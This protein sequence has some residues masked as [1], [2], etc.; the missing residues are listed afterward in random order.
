MKKIFLLFLITC[1]FIGEAFAQ[2]PPSTQGSEF[3]FS[4]MRARNDREK[5][6][7]LLVSSPED[8]TIKLTNPQTL[9]TN[10]YNVIAG[11]VL[12]IKLLYIPK[13]GSQENNAPASFSPSDISNYPHIDCYT[14]K[15]NTIQ[16]MGYLV[17]AY[18]PGDP[19]TEVK[20]SIY[21]SMLG[22]QTS[23]AANVL[24]ID[25]LGNEYYVVTRDGNN[26][27]SYDWPAEA[28]IMATEDNT[29][30]EISPTCLIE[31]QA[32]LDLTPTFDII[33]NK[34]QTYLLRSYSSDTNDE[35]R[36]DLTG[37]IIKVKDD[38]GT[39]KCKKI[40]V[41]AGTQH[42][43]GEN[44][45]H[46]NG[47]YEYEQLFPVHLWGNSFMVVSTLTGLGAPESPDVV[48]IVASKP[49]TKVIVNGI[50]VATLNQSEYHELKLSTP[51]EGAFISTSKPV[52]VALF[53]TRETGDR[54]GAPNMI[55]VA[56]IEQ[57]LN[58]I[59]FSPASGLGISTH[60]VLITS[61]T[62]ICEQTT[63]NGTLMNAANGYNWTTIANPDPV[64]DGKYSTI[65]RSIYNNSY[66][67]IN[68][69][70]PEK[71]GITAYVYG[72]G[73]KTGYGYSVGSAARST[74]A[75][76]I[77]DG[78]F[79]KNSNSTTT[80]CVGKKVLF[81]ALL[82]YSYSKI[83]WDFG[84]GD[85]I[86]RNSPIDT[87]THTFSDTK[88]YT[89]KMSV[90][91]MVSDCYGSVG[92]IDEAETEIKVAPVLGYRTSSPLVFC[93]GAT[94]ASNRA[95]DPYFAGNPVKYYWEDTG[96]TTQS[97]V[98]PD[99]HG[100]SN[101]YVVATYYECYY[102]YD[103]ID[104]V[105]RPIGGELKPDVTLCKG[106][107]I[108]FTSATP[109]T[110]G[111]PL[112]YSW[113]NSGETTQSIL[114]D[115]DFGTTTRHIV[116][117][118]AGCLYRDTI[119]VTIPAKVSNSLTASET[120]V[121]GDGNSTITITAT[122][123][124][125]SLNTWEV[126][127]DGGAFAPLTP[128]IDSLH[129]SYIATETKAFIY[130]SAG[131][132]GCENL[133]TPAV[134]VTANPPFT[135][136]LEGT[137]DIKGIASTGT[138]L[139]PLSGGVIDFEVTTDIAGSYIYQWTPDVSSTSSYSGVKFNEDTQDLIFSVDVSDTDGLCKASTNIVEVQLGNIDLKTIIYPAGTLNRALAD[140]AQMAESFQAG[141]KTVVYNRYGQVVS[142]KEN[143]GWDGTYKGQAADAGVYY[144][145]IEYNTANGK[146]AIKGVVE[147][148]K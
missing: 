27:M 64:L 96:E 116:S 145:V 24:P 46:T 81:E 53:P 72:D 137:D 90:H 23:D 118:E 114:I 135:A 82:P 52:E 56:P 77:L 128:N 125:P 40:A 43:S 32:G 57:Y 17:E 91:K 30:I 4:F 39:N 142:E 101:S 60:Q 51:A 7:T 98:L 102:I 104:V 97:I 3:Y 71:G 28:L 47:D 89:V 136:E 58:E 19:S 126:S 13:S 103:T 94:I 8:A 16:D 95:S 80:P 113:D 18:K 9:N 34:G 127:T 11:V 14:A 92:L 36:N 87:I 133:K 130:N 146:K 70:E 48:R 143:D 122:Q 44:S 112:A 106:T 120:H 76:F 63:I 79:T 121:C 85:I 84:D 148:V 59:T 134:N 124:G 74:E 141:Y 111:N 67:L 131:D 107:S 86:T 75:N 140:P 138:I 1:L 129:H 10:T 2:T 78:D 65:I 42:G 115:E 61:L 62:S 15:V 22:D 83:V 68:N 54:Q 26:N 139:L 144:Y 37:T 55:T 105:I 123:S 109:N 66:T 117:A 147:V 20:V 35:G 132:Y 38:G 50:E 110:N 93:K 45:Q 119:N 21:A 99:D 5:T 88:N 108:S 69:V 29:V 49:C 31:G 12:P 100:I 6:M 33:L 25:A 73:E 41:F